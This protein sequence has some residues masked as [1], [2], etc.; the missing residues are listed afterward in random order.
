MD[1]ERSE[2][3]LSDLQLAV[4]R[5]LWAQPGSSTTQVA[6]ALRAT[7][8]LAHTT[9]ATLLTRL[10]KRELVSSSRECRQL[11]YTARVSEAQVKRSM[12]SGLVSSLFQGDASA[13]MSHLLRTDEIGAADVE[14]V[15]ALLYGKEGR[16]D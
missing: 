4:M 15:R 3:S 8:P 5:A 1:E 2:V 10:E 9:V 13:L 7:R 6:E 12:V 11:M 14:Q 16:N